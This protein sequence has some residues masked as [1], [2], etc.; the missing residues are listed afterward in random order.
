MLAVLIFHDYYFP[1]WEAENIK[2]NY[3]QCGTLPGGP[4]FHLCMVRRFLANYILL[5]AVAGGGTITFLQMSGL[6]R[7]CR[8]G[9]SF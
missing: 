4:I 1:L 3:S 5:G 2:H 7:T 8:L 9:G 6:A